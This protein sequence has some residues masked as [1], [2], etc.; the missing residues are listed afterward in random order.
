MYDLHPECVMCEYQHEGTCMIRSWLDPFT[1]PARPINDCLSE[2]Y[3]E[4]YDDD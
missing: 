4:E 1:R 3:P 2:A